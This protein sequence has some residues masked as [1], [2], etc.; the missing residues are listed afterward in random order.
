[1]QV[2]TFSV[3][4]L[5]EL[6][7]KEKLLWLNAKSWILSLPPSLVLNPFIGFLNSVFIYVAFIV[8]FTIA[9]F[10]DEDITDILT[11]IPQIKKKSVT[12]IYW[13]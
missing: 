12:A 6:S 5:R 10:F 4:N 9:E 3:S 1:M 8:F 11:A 13:A 7:R 2:A